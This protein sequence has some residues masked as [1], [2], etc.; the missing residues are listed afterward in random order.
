MTSPTSAPAPGPP[1][2]P[3]RLSQK[4]LLGDFSKDFQKLSLNAKVAAPSPQ[5]AAATTAA[6]NNN[7][8]AMNNNNKTMTDAKES[9]WATFD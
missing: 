1:Q 6:V 4:D 9:T 7:N 5:S 3:A 8:A 2:R